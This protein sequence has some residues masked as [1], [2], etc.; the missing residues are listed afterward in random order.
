M[1]EHC[2]ARRAALL[3]GA[4][5]LSLCFAALVLHDV[6]LGGPDVHEAAER[7]RFSSR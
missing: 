5:L 4:A 7:H 1:R 3:G 6:L 2:A